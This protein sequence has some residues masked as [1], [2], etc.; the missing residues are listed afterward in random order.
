MKLCILL[1]GLLASP[2]NASTDLQCLA[3]AI[4]FEARGESLTGQLAVGHVILN[5]VKHTQFPNTICEVIY[6]TK[7]NCQFSWYCDGKPDTIPHS[8]SAELAQ[9]LAKQL[10]NNNVPDMTN[11]ALFFKRKGNK[12]GIEIGNHVFYGRF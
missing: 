12:N 10:L 7:P 1:L 9:T 2:T 3:K 4:Y 8:S 11:G 6:Q 5:R